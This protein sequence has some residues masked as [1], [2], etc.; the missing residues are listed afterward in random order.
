MQKE[1][2]VNKGN[3]TVSHLP[4]NNPK[5]SKPILKEDKNKKSTSRERLST[6]IVKPILTP[7]VNRRSV[8]PLNSRD[9]K[10]MNKSITPITCKLKEEENSLNIS[11]ISVNKSLIE[12]PIF[13]A[14]AKI[15]KF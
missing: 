11:I 10:F 12:N 15:G 13:E 2:I 6:N 4:K 7:V 9:G 5:L 8:S 3:K 14:P 1:N